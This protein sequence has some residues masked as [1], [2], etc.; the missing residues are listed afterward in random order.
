MSEVRIR[1]Y[2]DFWNF[3]LSWNNFHRV[4]D[5]ARTTPVVIP[6]EEALPQA[7]V[8]RANQKGV[9]VG[10]HVFA[11]I[12][13][14]SKA[15]KGLNRFLHAMDGFPG[16]NVTVK[17]RRPA[18]PV[19]C[20]HEGCRKVISDCPFCHQQLRRTVEKGIDTAL[21]TDI[22]KAAFDNT[23]DQA[24][25]ISEDSDFVPAVKFI[26]ERWTKQ[27]IHAYFRGRSDELRNACWKHSFID[28]FMSDL[29]PLSAH[30]AIPP[31]SS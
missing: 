3:Q 16:Y 8:A 17:E 22:I 19:K 6:W 9:Y 23:F 28:D 25:L 5:P 30:N 27:V 1:I 20:T 10:T 24:V 26:Q 15:D 18:S 12:D 21:L 31:I 14:N 4:K 7:L 2:I 11:S 29:V 13:P